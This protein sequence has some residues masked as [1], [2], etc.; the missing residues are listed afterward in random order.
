MSNENAALARGLFDGINNATQIMRDSEDRNRRIKREDTLYDQKQTQYQ[1]GQDDRSNALSR[2][3]VTES[4]DD[5]EYARKETD[6]VRLQK[7]QQALNGFMVRGDIEGTNAF[8]DEYSPEGMKPTVVMRDGKYYSEGKDPAT[9]EMISHEM[10]KDDIGRLLMRMGKETIFEDYQKQLDA[11]KT[12]A[13]KKSDQ[14]F[15]LKKI[16]EK[17]YQ[18]RK[19]KSVLN[20]SLTKSQLSNNQEIDASRKAISKLTREEV[21]SKTQQYTNTG[22]ENPDFDPYLSGLVKK[23]TNRKVGSDPDFNLVFNRYM[24]ADV[25]SNTPPVNGARKAKD[26]NWYV[27]QNN[28]WFKVGE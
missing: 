11:K 9:G 10:Q 19:N 26:G 27:K 1:Q 17:G 8:L 4:R 13:S 7:S 3:G 20:R 15:E 24:G 18:L 12:S 23:A 25:N 6:R 28:Q 14:E 5:T 2:R 16:R 21:L 22:R